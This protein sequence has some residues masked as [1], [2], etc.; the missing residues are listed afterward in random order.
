MTSMTPISHS[1]S[2]TILQRREPLSPKGS[3]TNSHWPG[4]SQF[5]L[6]EPITAAQGMEDTEEPSMADSAPT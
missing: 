2:T 1:H 4:V 3:S 5:I 6:L